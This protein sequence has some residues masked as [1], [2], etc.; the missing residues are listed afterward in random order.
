MDTTNIELFGESNIRFLITLIK[1]ELL[2][3]YD[4]IGVDAAINNA[5]NT[6]VGIKFTKVDTLPAPE[7]ADPSVIY[8]VPS[9][10]QTEENKYDEYFFDS[11][12]ST[13]EYFGSSTPDLSGYVKKTELQDVQN[14]TIQT[15]WDSVFLTSPTETA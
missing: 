2:K 4:K 12:N 15:I 6:V 11:V 9:S 8:M 10:S 14:S 13:F 3:Y 7:A 5:V 1:N